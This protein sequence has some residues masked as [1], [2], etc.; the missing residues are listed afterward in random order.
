MLTGRLRTQEDTG[1]VGQTDPPRDLLLTTLPQTSGTTKP[2]LLLVFPRQK[3]RNSPV[4]RG[5]MKSSWMFVLLGDRQSLNIQAGTQ[6]IWVN[7]FVVLNSTCL[8]VLLPPAAP[9]PEERNLENNS[10]VKALAMTSQWNNSDILVMSQPLDFITN[11]LSALKPDDQQ[12]WLPEEGPLP[13][14]S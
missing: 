13:V 6:W 3:I 7:E 14:F 9:R 10:G 4:L 1:T 8:L 2:N 11:V 5:W 12:L